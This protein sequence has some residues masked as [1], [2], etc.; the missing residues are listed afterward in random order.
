VIHDGPSSQFRLMQS[1]SF[2]LDFSA[3]WVKGGGLRRHLQPSD[4]SLS[5]AANGCLGPITSE[6]PPAGVRR[7]LPHAGGMA[8]HGLVSTVVDGRDWRLSVLQ[9]TSGLREE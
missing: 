7:L 9:L 5:Q 1:S 6:W 4:V 3:L 8:A 2:P